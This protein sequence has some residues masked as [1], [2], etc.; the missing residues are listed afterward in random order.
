MKALKNLDISQSAA[1]LLR[2][3]GYVEG[4]TTIESTENKIINF[5]EVSRVDFINEIEKQGNL[6]LS[7]R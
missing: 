1:K 4:S 3:N 2:S 6:I 5:L 7:G